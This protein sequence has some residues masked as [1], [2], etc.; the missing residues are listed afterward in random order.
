M[1]RVFRPLEREVLS[2]LVWSPVGDD[3]RCYRRRRR[4]VAI[5]S[6][7]RRSKGA[8]LAR[9]VASFALASARQDNRFSGVARARTA[10][11]RGRQSDQ[12][13]GS[14]KEQA[15]GCSSLGQRTPLS[16]APF[17]QTKKKI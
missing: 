13:G 6:L 2:P 9:A 5:L 17:E 12:E 7:R 1:D 14:P 4:V 10:C 11:R 3:G 8:L 16:P 15:N